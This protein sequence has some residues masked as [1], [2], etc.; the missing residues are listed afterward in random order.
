[1]ELL[2][3]SFRTVKCLLSSTWVSFGFQIQNLD[4]SAELVEDFDDCCS[5]TLE[6]TVAMGDNLAVVKLERILVRF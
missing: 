3:Y 4:A 1:V 5:T 6:N 2:L